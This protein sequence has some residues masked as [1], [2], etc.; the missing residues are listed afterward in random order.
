M[1][2]ISAIREALRAVW[3][4]PAL[5]LSEIAWRWSFAAAAWLLIALTGFEYLGSLTVSQADLLFLRTRHP[6]LVAR[7]L[8]DIFRDSGARLAQGTIIV[9]FALLVFWIVGASLGEFVTLR[10]LLP[11]VSTRQTLRPRISGSRTFRSLLGLNFVRA[12]LA[13]T[14]VI[15]ALGGLVLAGLIAPVSSEDVSITANLFMVII[16]VVWLLWSGLNWLLSLATLSEEDTFGSISAAVDLLRR[17]SSA[18][19]GVSGLFAFAHGF[20]FL[21]AGSAAFAVIG[22][23]TQIS[24]RAATLLLLIIALAYFAFV[25][26]LYIVRLAAYAAIAQSDPQ[27]PTVLAERGFP[28][29]PEP[30]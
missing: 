13:F 15:A 2:A 22:V 17:S 16:M 30:Q 4:Q 6:A 23:A 26:F 28:L 14:A 25:D 5:L 9:I 8:A 29:V 18:I 27:I 12:S 20:A 1:S 7:A 21:I 10:A 11:I 3:R 24:H 19:T